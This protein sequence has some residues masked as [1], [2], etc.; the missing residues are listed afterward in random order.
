MKST[1]NRTYLFS[2]RRRESF[3]YT[4]RERMI[5]QFSS[6]EPSTRHQSPVNCNQQSHA[7]GTMEHPPYSHPHMQKHHLDPRD[8]NPIEPASSQRHVVDDRGGCRRYLGLFFNLFTS[9]LDYCAFSKYRTIL[10]VMF[11]ITHDPYP[12]FLKYIN[13]FLAALVR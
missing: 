11:L 7:S 13:K 5:M 6:D 8:R 3:T 2:Y 10:T 9:I 12:L 4:R 1:R